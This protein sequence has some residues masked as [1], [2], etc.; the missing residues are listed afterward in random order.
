MNLFIKEY[1]K[2][3]NEELKVEGI[4]CLNYYRV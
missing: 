2:L 3:K 1:Y 4:N